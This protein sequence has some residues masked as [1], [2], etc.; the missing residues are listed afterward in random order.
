MR[1]G[2]RMPH[3][4]A[5]LKKFREEEADCKLGKGSS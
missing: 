4:G 3:E 5:R 1:G 2:D